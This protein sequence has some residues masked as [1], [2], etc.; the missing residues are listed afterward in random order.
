MKQENEHKSYMQ[1]WRVQAFLQEGWGTGSRME[2]NL[3]QV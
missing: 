1:Q 2:M 3:K